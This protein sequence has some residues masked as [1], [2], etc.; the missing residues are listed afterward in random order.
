MVKLVKNLESDNAEVLC[1]AGHLARVRELPLEGD[2]L[3][4]F[5]DSPFYWK[6]VHRLSKFK[7]RGIQV[8]RFSNPV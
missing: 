5:P 8:L 3:L 7:L 4:Y 6:G 2:A 1:P